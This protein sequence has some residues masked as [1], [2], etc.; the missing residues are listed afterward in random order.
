MLVQSCP[1]PRMNP[2]RWTLVFIMTARTLLHSSQTLT[3]LISLETS[4]VFLVTQIFSRMNLKNKCKSQ[5][6]Q[7]HLH[8]LPLRW[9]YLIKHLQ[10]ISA[11]KTNPLWIPSNVLKNKRAFGIVMCI[12]FIIN[13]LSY[14]QYNVKNELVPLQL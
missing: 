12:T 2:L 9:V 3:P 10:L 5:H 11:T 13:F 4:V 8:F 7:N 6:W 1:Q 14:H